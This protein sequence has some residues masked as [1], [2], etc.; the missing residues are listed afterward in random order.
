MEI[1]VGDKIRRKDGKG[2]WIVQSI[3]PIKLYSK[4]IDRKIMLDERLINKWE[5]IDGIQS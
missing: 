5:K 2:I 4:E 1:E 3:Y